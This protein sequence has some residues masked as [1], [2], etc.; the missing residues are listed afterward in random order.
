MAPN[1]FL[2]RHA[3]PGRDAD[4]AGACLGLLTWL[5]RDAA[6]SAT[7]RAIALALAIAY[8]VASVFGQLSDVLNL[9]GWMPV[10]IQVVFAVGFGHTLIA[11][12]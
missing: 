3:E 1:L 12:R 5:T 8:L 11:D 2:R 10:A 4:D 7:G 9:L 6:D